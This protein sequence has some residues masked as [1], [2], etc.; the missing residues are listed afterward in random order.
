MKRQQRGRIW[1]TGRDMT[2]ERDQLKFWAHT[3][4]GSKLMNLYGAF[5]CTFHMFACITQVLKFNIYAFVVYD[6]C[7]FEW[8][9]EKLACIG[10]LVISLL[11]ISKWYWANHGAKDGILVHSDWYHASKVHLLYLSCNNPKI[12]IPK[13]PTTKFFL[14]LPCVDECHE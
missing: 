3:S 4:R 13:I 11:N 5:E 8:W 2:K 10:Y 14:K 12:H 6:S 1:H 7:R 9:N